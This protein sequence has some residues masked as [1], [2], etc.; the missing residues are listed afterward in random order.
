[1][2]LW[3]VLVSVAIIA[4]L[5]FGW[6]KYFND[7]TARDLTFD[8]MM[9]MADE[10]AEREYFDEAVERYKS[11]LSIKQDLQVWQKIKET[12]EKQIERDSDRPDKL[13]TNMLEAALAF[14]LETSFWVTAIQIDIGKNRLKDAFGILTEAISAGAKGEELDALHKELLYA[15]TLEKTAYPEYQQSLSGDLGLFNGATWQSLGAN[16]KLTKEYEYISLP[17]AGRRYIAKVNGEMRVLDS[18]GTIRGR[19]AENGLKSGT[20]NDASM[21]YPLLVE[22]GWIYLTKDGERL[23]GVYEMAGSFINGRAAAKSDTGFVILDTS[24]KPIQHD[25]EEI[26]FD[27][28]GFYLQGNIVIAKKG[29]QWHLYDSEYNQISSF[30]CPGIDICVKGGLIAYSDGSLWGYVDTLGNVAI[31]PSFE[32]AK[33]FSNGLAAAKSG[34]LWG[35]IDQSGSF[36]ITPQFQYAGYLTPAA[37]CMISLGSLGGSNGL[38]GLDGLDGLASLAGLEV[39]DSLDGISFNLLT[40]LN[41]GNR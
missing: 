14:P 36:V 5:G 20:Y 40:L 10:S 22:E 21:I 7:L 34:G 41:Y 3:K 12:R 29:G 19:A 30:S 16:G 33:S 11:A 18:A 17:S 31:E 35:Y 24:G 38:D 9:A 37:T 26:A 2:K 25:F 28:E 39:S 1:M 27:H 23:P 32:E 8:E 6:S 4:I 15:F 13:R